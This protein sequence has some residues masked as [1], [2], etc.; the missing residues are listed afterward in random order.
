VDNRICKTC[1]EN[2]PFSDFYTYTKPHCKSCVSIQQKNA[3]EEKKKIVLEQTQLIPIKSVKDNNSLENI[4][5]I[6]GE[7]IRDLQKRVIILEEMLLEKSV[8]KLSIK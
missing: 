7:L 3:R 6:Q 8:R 2:K 5:R 1:H 4:V